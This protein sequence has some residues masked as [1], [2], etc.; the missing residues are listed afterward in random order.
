MARGSLDGFLRNPRHDGRFPPFEY[1][2]DDEDAGEE[3]GPG[4]G[5]VFVFQTERAVA[6]FTRFFLLRTVR[7]HVWGR[8]CGGLNVGRF[9]FDVSGPH[10]V[11][12]VCWCLLAEPGNA[13]NEI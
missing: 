5:L 8:F 3:D 9:G 1:Q 12:R 11:C 10:L 6:K 13:E 2:R 7:L 4:P